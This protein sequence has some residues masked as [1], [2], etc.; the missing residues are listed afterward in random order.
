MAVLCW[1]CSSDYRYYNDIH[2]FDT[3]TFR[4]I[5]LDVSGIPPSPR[6]GARFVYCVLSCLL[7]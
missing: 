2:A 1:L 6:S 7:L 5:K 4:W 3:D